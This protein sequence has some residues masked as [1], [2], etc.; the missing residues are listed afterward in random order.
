MND[1][2]RL[3]VDAQ[4]AVYVLSNPDASDCEFITLKP[5]VPES[6][7]QNIATRWA[8]RN[9]KGV[10]VAGLVNGIPQLALK[11]LPADSLVIVRL[12]AAYARYVDVIANPRAEQQPQR[13]GDFVQFATGLWSLDDSRSDA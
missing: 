11:E 2:E 10:G 9:F 12:T 7:I 4:H 13:A 1:L 5:M 3:A 8:G 6:E